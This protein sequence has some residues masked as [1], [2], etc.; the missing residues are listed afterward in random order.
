MTECNLE[1]LEF[2]GMGGRRVVGRFDGARMS[3][4]GGAMLLQEVDRRAVRWS[5]KIGQVA[6]AYPTDRRRDTR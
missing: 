1:Q 2:Q 5:R 4:D 6:K 3:S